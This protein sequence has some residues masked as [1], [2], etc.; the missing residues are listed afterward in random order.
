MVPLYFTT[1][2]FLQTVLVLSLEKDTQ[3]DKRVERLQKIILHQNRVN[4]EH[5][6]QLDRQQSVIKELQTDISRMN[7]EISD[8][9]STKGLDKHYATVTLFLTFQTGGT[10]RSWSIINYKT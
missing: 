2:L 1:I 10:H 8:C 6:I 5:Q 4:A 9:T 3:M 7:I